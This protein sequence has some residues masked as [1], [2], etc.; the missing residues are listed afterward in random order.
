MD[1][2]KSH[3]HSVSH[4]FPKS[5]C[6]SIWR[7]TCLPLSPRCSE[8][9]W[10]AAFV[11]SWTA[12]L[13]WLETECGWRG[14]EWDPL[15]EMTQQGDSDRK[16]RSGSILHPIISVLLMWLATKAL[17]NVLCLKPFCS[18]PHQRQ[19][20]FLG[21][22][23]QRLINCSLSMCWQAKCAKKHPQ[24]HNCFSSSKQRCA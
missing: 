17:P 4:S 20:F 7:Q 15:Y 13:S 10:P 1:D 14:S 18:H 5:R 6:G 11:W 2:G 21:I 8:L 23:Q 19:I 24:N 3:H 12:H 22:W 9:H 16:V